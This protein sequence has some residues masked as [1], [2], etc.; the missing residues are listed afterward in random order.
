MKKQ[1]VKQAFALVLCLAMMLIAAS[2]CAK[3]TTANQSASPSPTQQT[4]SD[5]QEITDMLGNKVTIP[6]TIKKVYCTSPIGTYIIY[7]IAPDRLIGWNSKMSDEAN[8]YINESYRNLPAL[9]GTM[10]GQNSF[11][12]EEI[13]KLNPDIIL[14]FAYNGEVSDM[15]TQLSKQSGIPVVTLDSSLAK[16]PEAYRL[17]GKIL[18]VEDR[19]TALAD[20]AQKTLDKVSSSVAK[21]PDSE[22]LRIYYVESA[23][24]LKT[25]GTDSMHTEVI[26]FVNATNV[27]TMDT[28]SSGKG[29]SV[30]MEQ[31]VNWNP[32]V[33]IANSQMG[34]N[35]FL[36]T[37]YN[38]KTWSASPL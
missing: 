6:K 21:V 32:D 28:S 8:Q 25:D 5:K 16:T 7:T 13:I 9:G 36:K 12:T 15:V 11:N 23:D 17:L 22:K 1:K 31:V 20:Y 29:T 19:G 4:A 3:T 18:G 27:V 37:V 30:S 10:G 38:N 26:N 35:E 33:I 2:G 14:D 24:G 34:G